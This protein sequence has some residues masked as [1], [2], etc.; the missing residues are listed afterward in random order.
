[1][2]LS[3]D[4]LQR[5]QEIRNLSPEFLAEAVTWWNT[6]AT[7]KIR[8]FVVVTCYYEFLA[9]QADDVDGFVTWLEESGEL[10]GELDFD[11]GL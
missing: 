10:D 11:S 2:E 6:Q 8:Q 4:D 3:E 5:V 7:Q 1:M 9:M